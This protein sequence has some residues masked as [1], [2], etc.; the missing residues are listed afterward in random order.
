MIDRSFAG[1]GAMLIGVD[2]APTA[3]AASNGLT[4]AM[5]AGDGGTKLERTP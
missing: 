4:E 2:G 3:P 1:S 5:N